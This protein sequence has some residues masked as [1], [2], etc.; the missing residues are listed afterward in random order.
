MTCPY[1]NKPAKYG[2]NEEF[3]GRR[4][5]R[6]YMCYYCKPCGA[7][8]GTH[9]NTD[10]PL[11]TMANKELRDWRRKAHAVFDPIWKSRKMKRQDAY[12]WLY[13]KTGRWIHMGESDIET[14]K[15]VVETVSSG[16]PVSS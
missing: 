11:G 14:C 1:C 10:K 16:L 13:N 9:N 3:Y 7:Y 2:P 12:R 6:S 5:G 4:Y 15:L 8:V